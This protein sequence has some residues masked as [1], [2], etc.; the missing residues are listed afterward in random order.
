MEASSQK[1]LSL[2][3]NVLFD[4]AASRDFAHE[5][6]ETYQGKGY[7]LVIAPT[8]VAELYF[9]RLDGDREERQLASVSL[10]K[11]STWDIRPFTLSD[12]QTDLAKRFAE[13][14][15]ELTYYEEAPYLDT[16]AAAHAELG[17]FNEAVKWSQ[18]AVEKASA[19][20]R[21]QFETRRKLYAQG[22]KFQ[23]P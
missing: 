12:I 5:F 2:D 16:L 14:A 23:S 8:V 9:L 18:R 7:S 21:V 10:A 3:T 19:D 13:E 1:R 15:C 17:D 4:L 6:R 11:L 22:K 20:D